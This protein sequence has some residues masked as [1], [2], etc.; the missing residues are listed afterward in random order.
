MTR[1]LSLKRYAAAESERA[2]QLWL[3]S[4]GPGASSMIYEHLAEY[5]AGVEP[6]LEIYL[7][8]HR[9]T[10]DSSR[11]GCEAEESDGSQYDF[12]GASYGSFWGQRYLQLF[13]EQADAVILDAIAPP[14]VSLARQD[15]DA[16][17]ASADLF[18]ACV[19]DPSCGPRFGDDPRAF[20]L[21]LYDR[22][23]AGHCPG[24]QV[25]GPARLLL[26]RAFGQMLMS[27]NARQLIPA[28]LARADR[29]NAA[30]VDAI[31]TL[32]GFHFLPD[33]ASDLVLREWGWVLSYYVVFSELWET[34]EVSL[35]QM[36]AWRDQAAVSR[37]VTSGFDAPIAVLPRYP[38]DEWYGGFAE[39]DVPLLMLQ[40]TWDP[41]TRHAKAAVLADHFTGEHQHWVDIPR[42]AHGALGTLPTTAGTSC[43]TELVLSF[44]ADP[45]AVLDTSCLDDLAPVTFEGGPELNQ[46]LFGTEDAWGDP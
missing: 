46:L 40:G 41:A 28:A 18:Q 34:P 11:L 42:G 8:D 26:R 36:A 29:C 43:G 21:D 45:T 44:V 20:A 16:D 17:E 31:Q 15:I 9:G 19:D 25:Y 30:D 5:L 3:L 35:E 6:S 2:T 27:W 14:D 1:C 22:L 10:G 13:P 4:G 7:P 12:Y 33:P 38:R 39:T 37:D 32:F 23:D 24:I